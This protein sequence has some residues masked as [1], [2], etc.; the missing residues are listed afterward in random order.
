[1][2]FITANGTQLKDLILCRKR[3]NSKFTIFQQQCVIGVEVRRGLTYKAMCFDY[4]P[5]VSIRP[6]ARGL[7]GVRPDQ[8]LLLPP[9]SFS[10]SNLF[11]IYNLFVV[12]PSLFYFFNFYQWL[13]KDDFGIQLLLTEN[14]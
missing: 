14:V 10:L 2:S 6:I 8:K 7:L 5:E 1:M 12:L 4:L 11:K 3:S 13:L 9:K